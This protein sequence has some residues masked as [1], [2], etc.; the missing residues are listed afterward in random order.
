MLGNKILICLLF[1]L[2][3]IGSI[4]AQDIETGIKLIKNQKYAGAKKL[5]FILAEYKIQS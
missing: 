5:F 4:F 1:A 2:I 3:F